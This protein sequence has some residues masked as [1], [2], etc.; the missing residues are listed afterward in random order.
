MISSHSRTNDFNQSHL[1]ASRN[2]SS[3]VS[4]WFFRPFVC[5]RILNVGAQNA[6]KN[7]TGTTINHRSDCWRA[8]AQLAAR[9]V[10]TSSEHLSD[11]CQLMLSRRHLNYCNSLFYGI[12][13]GLRASCS[14]ARMQLHVW[15]LS[16]CVSHTLTIPTQW[17][18]LETV[19][20]VS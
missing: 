19:T 4:G 10:S 13:E 7:R 18:K 17:L 12:S 14:L 11:P 1:N 6:Y 8:K 9:H 15:C 3:T 16:V 5:S 20:N 2:R